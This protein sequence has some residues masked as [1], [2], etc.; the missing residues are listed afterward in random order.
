MITQMPI[1]ISMGEVHHHVEEAL[2]ELRTTKQPSVQVSHSASLPRVAM[3][4][5]ADG[6][7][8]EP[9]LP[10]V[11]APG[12]GIAGGGPRGG[13]GH[14]MSTGRRSQSDSNVALTDLV[15]VRPPIKELRSLSD[16]GPNQDTT[17]AAALASA[18]T[19]SRDGSGESADGY[20]CDLGIGGPAFP[21]LSGPSL[22][23]L[24]EETSEGG[25][26]EGGVAGVL[27]PSIASRPS[28][29]GFLPTSEQ[30]QYR[31]T[32]S[33][34]GSSKKPA[35]RRPRASD[36]SNVAVPHP[37][38]LHRLS[39]SSG[40]GGGGG[41][42]GSAAGGIKRAS[43]AKLAPQTMPTRPSSGKGG[44]V[45]TGAMKSPGRP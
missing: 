45:P 1:Q 43:S 19:L 3:L 41:G 25:M 42:G 34:G 4:G 28:S 8:K 27:L 20:E 30:R 37:P 40:S 7:T 9:T 16:F 21:T 14:K 32:T 13:G 33:N 26:G 29:D 24:V 38:K 44:L 12:G 39:E 15:K 23:T 35:A 18:S 2:D 31:A 17:V 36:G 11:T 5:S 10:I 22:T 6:A